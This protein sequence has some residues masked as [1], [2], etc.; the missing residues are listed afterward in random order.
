MLFELYDALHEN[1]EIH[2]EMT[3]WEARVRNRELRDNGDS[4]RWVACS[5]LCFAETEIELPEIQP[6]GR[7]PRFRSEE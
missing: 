6:C 3:E 1:R 7:N 4:Q 5:C 2:L